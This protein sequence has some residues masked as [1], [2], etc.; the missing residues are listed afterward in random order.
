MIRRYTEK[1]PQGSLQPEDVNLSHMSALAKRDG[2]DLWFAC[3]KTDETGRI[4]AWSL[5]NTEAEALQN[6][7]LKCRDRHEAI[8]LAHK[9]NLF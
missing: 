1:F 6:L 9:Q 7:A 5:G 3:W 4:A 8:Q 2:K